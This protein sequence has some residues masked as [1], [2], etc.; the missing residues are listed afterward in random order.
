MRISALV[1]FTSSA[2]RCHS[3]APISPFQAVAAKVR[4]VEEVIGPPEHS[5]HYFWGYPPKVAMCLPSKTLQA[6][7][8][9]FGCADMPT[10][11]SLLNT[12]YKAI[13][14]AQRSVIK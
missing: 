9:V 11:E 13:S 5:D 14:R 2:L 4:T 1:H 7:D 6:G 12:S 10:T 8:R 3:A